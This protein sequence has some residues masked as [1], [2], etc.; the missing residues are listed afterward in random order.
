MTT[1]VRLAGEDDAATLAALRRAW[2]A[3]NGGTA[4]DIEFEARF[5]QWWAA[6]SGRRLTWVAE[7]DG[8][9]IGMLNLAVFTRMPQPGRPATRWG[10]LGNAFVLAAHRDRGVGRLMLDALLEHADREGFV[11][12]VLSPSPRSVPFYERA[13]FGPANILLV[14]PFGG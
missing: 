11:R 13:G 1:T 12:V 5:A 7:A 10:Y 9:P 2:T 6:E 3:E 4:A 14:R 8:Q